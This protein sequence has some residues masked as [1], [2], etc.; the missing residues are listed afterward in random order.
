MK[1]GPSW[2]FFLKLQLS[3]P[4]TKLAEIWPTYCQIVILKNIVRILISVVRFWVIAFFP[5]VIVMIGYHLLHLLITKEQTH[6][7]KITAHESR[8]L[9]QTCQEA[10]TII[11][12]NGFLSFVLADLDLNLQKHIYFCK[13]SSILKRFSILD[14]LNKLAVIFNH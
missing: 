14:F 3:N 13:T 6:T 1:I 9:S 12:L 5:Q 11:D 2:A 7:S 8:L 10:N 4:W